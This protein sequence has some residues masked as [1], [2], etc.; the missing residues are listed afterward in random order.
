MPLINISLPG[1]SFMHV[2]SPTNAVGVGIYISDTCN[3]QQTFSYNLNVRG[4]ED[5]WVSIT[6]M[7]T[8]SKYIIGV[9]YRHPDSNVQNFSESLNDRLFQLNSKR[10]QFFILGDSNID[11]SA[12][13]LNIASI[14][15]LN[16]LASHGT[17]SLIEK[18]TRVTPTSVTI[19]DH[20][21][22]NVRIYLEFF[23]ASYIMI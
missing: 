6:Y 20:A 23:L 19:L 3:H 12:D 17:K 16:S 11:T 13:K 5:L 1:Y 22:T 8:Q 21:L 4:C 9:I 18:P 7:A 14:R 15:Y 10:K 2:N